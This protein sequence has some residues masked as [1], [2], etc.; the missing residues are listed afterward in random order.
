MPRDFAPS[1]SL[2]LLADGFTSSVLPETMSLAGSHR[3]ALERFIQGS[4]DNW[5]FEDR[6]LAWLSPALERE[7]V[8][9]HAGRGPS[10]ASRFSGQQVA[11]LDVDLCEALRLH[12]LAT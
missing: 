8:Y 3:N 4:P 2:A 10:M 7:I 5:P 9:F 11:H 6:V 12:L 1:L